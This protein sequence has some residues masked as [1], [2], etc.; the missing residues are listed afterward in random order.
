MPTLEE[1]LASF[2]DRLAIRIGD[3]VVDRLTAMTTSGPRASDVHEAAT[4]PAPPPAPEGR[5][6]VLAAPTQDR[7]LPGGMYVPPPERAVALPVEGQAVRTVPVTA[8]I[9]EP[10]LTGAPDPNRRPV[11]NPHMT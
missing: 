3:R 1:V 7:P 2:V 5:R 4:A 6:P 9:A 11:Q 10:P 8:K